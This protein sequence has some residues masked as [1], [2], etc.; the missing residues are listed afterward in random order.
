MPYKFLSNLL[1]FFCCTFPLCVLCNTGGAVAYSHIY[2]YVYAYS[3]T[4][5]ELSSV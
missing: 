2:M 4:R 1:D 3:Q 5:E